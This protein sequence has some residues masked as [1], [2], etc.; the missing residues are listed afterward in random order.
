MFI[1]Y[2][3]FFLQDEKNYAHGL[4]ILTQSEQK[5]CDFKN[6][7]EISNFFLKNYTCK[8]FKNMQHRIPSDSN[9][10]ETVCQ[11]CTDI[12]FTFYYACYMQKKTEDKKEIKLNIYI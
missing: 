1:I 7:H 6:N 4:S 9:V 12:V 11:N 3:G 5:C 2:Q 8:T 10:S